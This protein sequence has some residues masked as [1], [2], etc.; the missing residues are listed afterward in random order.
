MRAAVRT[1]A[2]LLALFLLASCEA[3]GF[4]AQAARGQLAIVFGREDIRRLLDDPSLPAER[5][6]A[7]AEALRIRDFAEKELALPVGGNYAAFVDIGR[8][9]AVWNVFAAPEFSTEPVDWCFPVAG[10]VSYRGYFSEAGAERYAAR[11]EADGLDVYVGGVAAYSTLGWFDDPLLSTV[12]SRPAHQLAGLIFH[13]LAHQIAYVPGDTTFNESFATVVERE[14]VRRWLRAGGQEALV[15]A[16]GRDMRRRRQFA[17][18]VIAHRGR[19][20]ALYARDLPEPEKRRDKARLQDEL[21]RAYAELKA[22]WGGYRG[23]DGWFA[24]PLNNAQ[25][26]TVGFYNEL[27]PFFEEMLARRGGDLEAF[28]GEVRELA[29]LDET[30]R[31]RR[32]S[33]WRAGPPRR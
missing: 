1:A 21:R 15:E 7:L 25:L 28:Y 3:A 17:E 2:P 24:R 4:Y 16:A 26:S 23:Y 18:L 12:L 6:A 14:G 10:C 22:E 31:D 8:E 20:D 9:H 13:E 19:F 11:L 5:R 29:A 30:A 32:L 27:A 33:A